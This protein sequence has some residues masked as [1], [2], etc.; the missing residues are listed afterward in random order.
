MKV[1]T[2]NIRCDFG[3]DGRNNF[4][5]RKALILEKIKL[6]QPDVICFQE[7]LPHVAG[8]LKENLESYYV[9]GCGRDENLEDEQTPV[10]FLKMSYQ[11]VSMNTFWLSKT[12]EIPASRYANQSICPRICTEVLLQDIKT[13]ELF[14]IVNTHLDHEGSDARILGMGQ[15][16]NY[17]EQAVLFPEAACIL[18]GDMNAFP[19]GPEIQLLKGSGRWKDLTEGMEGTFH[20]YGRLPKPEKIDYI[21]ASSHIVCRRR[22]LWKDCRD[23]VFLSDHYPV[24]VEITTK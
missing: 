3:Q 9:V 18:A 21:A 19:H 17:L 14:R 16:L 10:A 4:C 22:G 12:P 24:F 13:R 5:H 23:G 2:F 15:I 1:V 20:D 11:M 6:E 8:W 7:V